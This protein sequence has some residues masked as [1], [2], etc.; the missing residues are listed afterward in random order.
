MIAKAGRPPV[1]VL[2]G[3]HALRESLAHLLVTDGLTVLCGAQPEDSSR[4]A[5]VV[6]A[7]NS[8]PSGWSLARLRSAYRRVPC[9]VLSASP[10]AGDFAANPLP[11]GY[12]VQLPAL[13]EEI[14]GLVWELSTA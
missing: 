14:L 2:C 3:H 6:V 11:H 7:C 5:V 1:L 8:W 13:P 4:P 12:F 10:L 9:L